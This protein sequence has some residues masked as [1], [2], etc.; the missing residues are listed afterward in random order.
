METIQKYIE[1]ARL[2]CK[3]RLW[4]VKRERSRAVRSMAEGEST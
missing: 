4:G 3:R 1:L 2:I